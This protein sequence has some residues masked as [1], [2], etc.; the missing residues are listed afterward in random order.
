[1][2]ASVIRAPGRIRLSAGQGVC[3]PRCAAVAHAA[4]SGPSV[5]CSAAPACALYASCLHAALRLAGLLGLLLACLMVASDRCY[6]LQQQ[7]Q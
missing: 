1:M 3:R 6:K 5:C 2:Y 7:Q 4:R